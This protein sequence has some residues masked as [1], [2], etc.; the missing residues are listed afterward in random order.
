MTRKEGALGIFTAG[1][2]AAIRYALWDHPEAQDRL[3]GTIIL[4]TGLSE[5]IEKYDETI[6]D[7]LNRG[8]AVAMMDWRGQGLSDRPLPN[9][10]KMHV[11]SF[12]AYVADLKQFID[13]IVAPSCPGPLLFL[14][15]SMGAHLALRYLHDDRAVVKGA[16]LSAPMLGIP[17]PPGFR[18]MTK[19]LANAALALGKATSYAPGRGDYGPRHRQ[20]KNNPLTSDPD[21]FMDQHRA[22]DANP[23]LA[24]GGPTYGW[25]AAALNSIARF[26]ERAYL[27]AFTMPICIVQAGNERVVD[28]K[29]QDDFASRVASCTLV[30]VEGAEHELLKER[31]DLRN[32]FWAAFDDF[33][34]L[35]LR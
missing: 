1:D 26:K 8:F 6:N 23:D 21:R 15:H 35:I 7:L 12:D 33:I 10:Y 3:K 20:F 11:E 22:I 17:F 19:S 13:E 31:D 30:R 5:F 25:L 27:K 28:N 9:R 18:G 34:G 29:A 14:A 16:V 24:V 4:L 2:G 32:Q